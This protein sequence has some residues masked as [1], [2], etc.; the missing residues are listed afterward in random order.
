MKTRD[1]IIHTAIEM[2]NTFGAGEVST[3]RIAG[4]MGISPGNLYYHFNTKEE[5]VRSIWEIM[6]TELD[7]VWGVDDVHHSEQAIAEFLQGLSSVFYRY[8]FFYLELPV[9]MGRDPLLK[10][11]YSARTRRMLERFM[12]FT[13]S[14]IHLG[15]MRTI[16]SEKEQTLLIRN[17]WLV[18]QLWMYYW[19]TIYGGVTVDNVKQGMLQVLSLYHPYLSPDASDRIE[20]IIESS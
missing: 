9:L 12:G 18:S 13:R 4:E 7:R 3:K 17:M 11:M 16:P 19:H 15:I 14:W 10:D 1:R 5:L 2:F 20:A 6:E 8:R